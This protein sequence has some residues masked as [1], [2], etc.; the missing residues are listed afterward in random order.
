LLYYPCIIPKSNLNIA[1]TLEFLFAYCLYL[2]IFREDI[3]STIEDYLP[4]TGRRTV[5][6]HGLFGWLFTSLI[7]FIECK[8]S[9][10]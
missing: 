7:I 5:V 10:L 8:W 2:K 3:L 4:R 6:N 1:L 9:I